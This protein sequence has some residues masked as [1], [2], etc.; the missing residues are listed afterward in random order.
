MNMKQDKHGN[1]YY[2]NSDGQ[3]H[4]DEDLPAVEYVGGKG[5]LK[6]REWWKNGWPHRDNDLP[7][8]EY[9]DGTWECWKNGEQ[10]FPIQEHEKIIY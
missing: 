3:L 8:V 1:T 6:K 10:Y 5:F 7:A 9:A 2:F 4:R